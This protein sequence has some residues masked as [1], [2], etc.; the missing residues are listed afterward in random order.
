VTDS[1]LDPLDPRLEEL[2][3]QR[4]GLYEQ[5]G[6]VG[7]FRRGS[8]SENYRRCGKA[9]CACAQPDHPGHG[10][11]YLWTRSVP[12]RGTRGR[13]LAA[14]EVGKVRGE[15][16]GYDRFA[17]LSQRIVEVNEAI[18]EARPAVPP[19]AAGS[20]GTGDENGGSPT[21]PEPSSKPRSRRRSPPR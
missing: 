4:A 6:G 5:L 20:P 3:A 16:A 9:N 1:Q 10:P 18:C 7:D 13:Q 12:G 2:Q 8:I 15:L 21:G 14:Q 19:A 17:A 11:R